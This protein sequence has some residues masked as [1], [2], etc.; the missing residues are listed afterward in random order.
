[1]FKITHKSKVKSKKNSPN[2]QN[3]MQRLLMKSYKNLN[4]TITKQIRG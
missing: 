3:K 2:N 4:S 1:M